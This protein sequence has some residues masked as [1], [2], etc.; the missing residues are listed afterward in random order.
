M[1]DF[2]VAYQLTDTME[3]FY[4]GFA[5]LATVIFA[6]ITGAYYFLHKAPRMTKVVSYIFLLFAVIFLMINNFGAFLHFL[7][8]IDQME[9][10]ATLDGVSPIIRGAANGTT[11]TLA[12]AG[13]AAIVPVVLGVL[14]MCYWMTF[15][16]NGLV[17]DGSSEKPEASPELDANANSD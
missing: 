5:V 10:Q 7:S 11:R 1:T 17:E 3:L 14:V 15:H 9:Y 16:W 8:V 12:L 13:F 4:N 2:E 6:Y